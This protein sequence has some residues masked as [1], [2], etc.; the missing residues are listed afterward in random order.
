M[1]EPSLDELAA[2]PA[3]QPD[4][5]VPWLD[6]AGSTEA[7]PDAEA[8]LEDLRRPRRRAS[9]GKAGGRSS[10]GEEP[11]DAR[12]EPADLAEWFAAVEIGPLPRPAGGGGRGGAPGPGADG[13]SAVGP[14]VLAQQILA[15]LNPEQA[16][17]VST[18]EGPLLILAGA[19][20]GK[21]RV[22][23]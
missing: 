9:R 17:A 22:L 20:S 7:A 12:E 14:A 11:A 15:R 6:E 10:V 21:T 23:A 16:R 8:P 13:S 1:T 19:G 5:L 3:A 18:T 4:E 2:H